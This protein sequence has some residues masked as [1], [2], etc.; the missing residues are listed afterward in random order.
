MAMPGYSGS[1][2][3]GIRLP[4]L[5]ESPGSAV[6]E[7]I[8][9]EIGDMGDGELEEDDSRQEGLNDDTQDELAQMGQFVEDMAVA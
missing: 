1:T 9:L 2:T 5:T 3:R 4:D 8:P 6:T 7:D